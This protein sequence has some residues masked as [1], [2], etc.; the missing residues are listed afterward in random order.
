MKCSVQIC[1]RKLSAR[2]TQLYESMYKMVPRAKNTSCNKITIEVGYNEGKEQ[3]MLLWEPSQQ[4]S[5]FG[6]VKM[7]R[8]NNN[9]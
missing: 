6:D 5:H 2:D 7:Q 1:I 3:L 8:Y 9:L 4:C